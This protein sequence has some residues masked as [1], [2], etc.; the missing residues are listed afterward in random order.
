MKNTKCMVCGSETRFKMKLGEIEASFCYEHL[1]E[2][3]EN[4]ILIKCSC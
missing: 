3:L 1:T 4:R 2:G